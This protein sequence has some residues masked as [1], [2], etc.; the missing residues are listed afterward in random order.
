MDKFK[1]PQQIDRADKI[2]WGIS[3][4][5]LFILV[6]GG[7]LAYTIYV[8]FAPITPAILHLPPVIVIACITVAFA[9]IEIEN[10]SF[11]Q[12]IMILIERVVNPVKRT[13]S[14]I[15]PRKKSY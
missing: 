4:K 15:P 14:G 12:I 11:V 2:F 8:Q 3:I 13:F 7:L 1:I 6:I 9:F 5:Q 10:A